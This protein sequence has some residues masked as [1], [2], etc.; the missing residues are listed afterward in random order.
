MKIIAFLLILNGLGMSVWFAVQNQLSK[1]LLAISGF[2]LA[3]GVLFAFHERVTEFVFPWGGSMK[4]REKAETDLAE[5]SAIRQRVE[6]Q[7]ATVDLVAKDAREARKLTDE[8]NLRSKE[9]EEKVKSANSSVEKASKTVEELEQ[10]TVFTKTFIAAQ[11]DD[12]KA[13][14]QLA[15]W[16]QDKQYRFR[17]EAERAWAAVYDAHGSGF[18]TTPPAPPWKPGATPEKLSFDEVVN[19]YRDS[20]GWVKSS[21]LHYLLNRQDFSK[22]KRVDIAMEAMRTTP[23]LNL[24]ELAGRGLNSIGSLEWKPLTLDEYEKWYKE[25][26]GKLPD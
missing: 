20:I 8:I 3:L 23:S 17:A 24:M 2:M 22:R 5:I 19:I 6:A 16:S 26:A 15:S 25:S 11:T 18:Y 4:M 10:L 7:G 14:D 12:R 1:T 9:I 21:V 13:F